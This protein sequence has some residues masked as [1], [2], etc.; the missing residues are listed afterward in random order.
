MKTVSSVLGN[1]LLALLPSASR[2][3]LQND[4]KPI[5]LKLGSI[6][7]EVKKPIEYAYFPTQGI[8][9]AVTVMRDGSTIELATIGREG[10]VGSPG[11]APGLKSGQ[12]VLVQVAGHGLRIS[13]T[14]L[15]REVQRYEPTSHVFEMYQAAFY[16]HVAQ[17]VACN[18]LHN[19]EERCCRWL[20]MSHDRVDSDEIRLT[21]EYLSYMLGVRRAS[22]TDILGILQGKKLIVIG[23]G[24]ITILNRAANGGIFVRVLPKY[25]G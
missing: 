19:V 3:R 1:K 16:Y 8:L 24:K 20:L 17:S 13:A 15:K 14:L 7:H 6:L 2:K 23:R 4:L 9:S 18:G 22:V 10:A 21:H 25:C 11:L 12:R 5:E